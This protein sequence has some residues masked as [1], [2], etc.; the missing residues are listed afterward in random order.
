MLA[1][2]TG[3]FRGVLPPQDEESAEKG[4]YLNRE[5][6]EHPSGARKAAEKGLVSGERPEEHTSGAR[7]ILLMVY[8]RAS[9]HSERECGRGHPHDSRTGVRRYKKR[10]RFRTGLR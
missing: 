1:V 9:W 6:E 7:A 8:S 3:F 2:P 5:P 4:L 10:R